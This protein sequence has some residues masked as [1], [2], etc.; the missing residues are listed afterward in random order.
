MDPLSAAP[1]PGV[2]FRWP[3]AFHPLPV[4]PDGSADRLLAVL[5]PPTPDY[6]EVR[7]AA[8]SFWGAL[9]GLQHG[10]GIVAAGLCNGRLGERLTGAYVSLSLVPLD[11]G[12]AEVAALGMQESLAGATDDADEVGGVLRDGA[13]V[14]GVRLPAGPAVVTTELREVG[15]EQTVPA[16]VLQVRMPAPG[17]QALLMITLMTPVLEDFTAYCEDGAALASS[18][19][20]V[21]PESDP[22]PVDPPTG[23]LGTAA[24]SLRGTA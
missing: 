24:L 8:R 10:H 14:V 7:A 6:D 16:G 21:P 3:P 22:D 13:Y 19:R 11:Y 4:G 5:F 9:G 1:L 17:Y 15:A 18:V 20:F 2:R 12:S 23:L